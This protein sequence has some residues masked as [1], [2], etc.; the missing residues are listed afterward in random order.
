MDNRDGFRDRIDQ[1]IE[2]L[3]LVNAALLEAGSD[4]SIERM[5]IFSK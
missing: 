4:E 5:S 1:T 2:R 3:N